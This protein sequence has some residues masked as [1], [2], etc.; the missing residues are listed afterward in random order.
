M[1]RGWPW[2]QSTRRRILVYRNI[3]D[4]LLNTGFKSRQITSLPGG[5]HMSRGWP[6]YQST[7]RHILVYRNIQD[8]LLNT[9]FKWGQITSLPGEGGF[10]C[11]GA[12]PGTNPQGVIS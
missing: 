9:G 1:S 5:V 7:R 12:G 10:T 2:Y 4:K 3:Q 11:L 8:K 6:W